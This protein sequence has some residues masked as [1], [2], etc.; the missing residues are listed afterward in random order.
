MAKRKLSSEQ[1]TTLREDLKKGVAAKKRVAD[2]LR[3]VAK[4][5]GITTITAR[6]YLKGIDGA[7]KRKAKGRR[8]P[9]RPPGRRPGRPA[10]SVS[11]SGLVKQVEDQAAKSK[12]ASKI[13]PRWQTL[14]DR[15]TLLRRKLLKVEARLEATSAKAGKL[16]SR[17][18]EL[19]A[20]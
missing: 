15:G 12:E 16:Y 10:A 13:V 2:L 7:P 19:V 6:W 11:V 17:I 1:R 4:K 5:Y 9:G 8:G 3:E 18:Q 14:V 20:R